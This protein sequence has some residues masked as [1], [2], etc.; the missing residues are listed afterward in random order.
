MHRCITERRR[1]GYEVD[2]SE[3]GECMCLIYLSR[4][5]LGNDRTSIRSTV[6]R[7]YP[8]T[9]AQKM[10][11]GQVWWEQCFGLTI[12]S[13]PFCGYK[14]YPRKVDE[15]FSASEV[16]NQSDVTCKVSQWFNSVTSRVF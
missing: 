6:G 7:V 11:T 15:R 14:V 3:T 12:F 5:G 10:G 8:L 13:L 9:Y 2:F 1:S 16:R 4:D